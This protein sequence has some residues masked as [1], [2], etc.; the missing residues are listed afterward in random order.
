MQFL[1]LN[2]S[3]PPVNSYIL[4]IETATTA[5]SVAISLN[6]KLVHFKESNDLQYGHAEKLFPYIEETIK[7]SNLTYKDLSAVAVSKGPGSYT[8][9]RIGVSA[10]KGLCYG[11]EIPLIGVSTLQ[12]MAKDMCNKFFDNEL[13]CPMIDARRMEVYTAVYDQTNSIKN[14]V[15]AVILDENFCADFIKKNKIIFFGDGSKKAETL[16]E[17]NSNAIFIDN[18]FP[19]AKHMIEIAHASFETKYFEDIAYFEPAYLKEFVTGNKNQ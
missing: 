1:K 10:A 3:L 12:S 13:F 19:S 15:E 18:F 7:E 6:G 2:L 8:G 16:F 9:L 14:K 5:C 4:H 11:L 17:G